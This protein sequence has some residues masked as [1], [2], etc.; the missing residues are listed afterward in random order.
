MTEPRDTWSEHYDPETRSYSIPLS[1]LR[2]EEH[3]TREN[4]Q[5]TSDPE[6]EN[7]KAF[8]RNTMLN[9]D[10]TDY[11]TKDELE[12]AA[13][14]TTEHVC[15]IAERGW[16]FEGR[17]REDGTL[18]NASVVRSWSNGLGIG[19]LADPE[20]KDDYTLDYVGDLSIAARAVIAEIPLRW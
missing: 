11:Y 13:Y 5:R 19:G 15:V 1:M 14:D 20:H 2:E 9:I 17:K 16:I 12:V 7:E 3:D 4:K 8:R 10:G 18:A 6:R